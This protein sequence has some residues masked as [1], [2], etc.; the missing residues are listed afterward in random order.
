MYL[1]GIDLGTTGCKSMLFDEKGEIYGDSYIEYDL[2]FTKE[3]IEQDANIWW[4]NVKLS[5]LE[6]LKKASIDGKEVKALSVSSQGIAGVPIDQEGNTLYHA[7][8]WLDARSSEEIAEIAE[9]F[10][11]GEIFAR[12]GKQ[13]KPYSFPQLLWLKKNRPE[14]YEKTWKYLMPHDFILYRLTGKTMT[15]YSM[16]SGTLIYDIHQKKWDEKLPKAFGFDLE[17]WP[18]IRSLGEVAGKVLP[19]VAEEMGLSPETL[20]V[21]GAQDQRCCSYGAGIEE[22]V[23]TIS[24]GTASAVCSMMDKAEIDPLHFVTCC[25]L[26]K[27]KWMN[28]TVVSTCG[29][30]L[31][32]LKTTLFDQF[33][34][35]ELDDMANRSPVGANGVFFLPYLS[36]EAKGGKAAGT[37]YG[38]GLGTTKEEMVRA[39]LEGIAFQFALHIKHH[40]RMGKTAHELRVFGGGAK[41]PIW[42][43]MIADITG[44][45]VVVPRT[46]EAGNL[47]AAMIAAVGAGIYEHIEEARVMVGEPQCRYIPDASQHEIYQKITKEYERLSAA[48]LEF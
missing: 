44:K 5:V 13:L 38:L 47:G 6:T 45:E 34:Y 40:E 16:A 31:K 18:E 36:G 9:H 43:Q 24:L 14:V 23:I 17:I 33:S 35:R 7:L 26:L 27:D 2:I 15:D 25:G 48:M 3:G 42:C 19:K 37:F 4:E 10:D 1:L 20:A 8:S 22:G 39:L 30:A 29:A 28:E 32:W 11:A 46:T 12:T 21:V 41:S